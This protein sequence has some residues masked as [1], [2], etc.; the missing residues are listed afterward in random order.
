MCREVMNNP[1]QMRQML[2]PQNMQAMM[3]MQQAMQ[4]LQGTG[5]IPPG[6]EGAGGLQG[7]GGANVPIL[8]LCS[9]VIS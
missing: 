3:Q 8:R 9:F 4:Q 6:A 2:N 5:L 1:E 7:L